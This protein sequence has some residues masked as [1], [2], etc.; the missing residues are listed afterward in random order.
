MRLVLTGLVLIAEL[1]ALLRLFGGRAAVGCKAR[2]ATAIV[3]LPLLGL[4]AWAMIGP[5][6]LRQP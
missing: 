6:A 4:A 1:W 5:S 2:W 3:L